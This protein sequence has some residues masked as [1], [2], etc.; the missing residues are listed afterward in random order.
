MCIIGRVGAGSVECRCVGPCPVCQEENCRKCEKRHN[1]LRKGWKRPWLLRTEPSGCDP[2][3]W[4]GT[5]WS[6]A[7][8]W[9]R[10]WPCL[11]SGAN[12][13][14]TCT[15][16]RA[17][18]RWWRRPP[19][20]RRWPRRAPDRPVHTSIPG[21][22]L[23][24]WTKWLVGNLIKSIWLKCFKTFK[25]INPPAGLLSIL[26]AT[27]AAVVA[28]AGRARVALAAWLVRIRIERIRETGPAA[29][30]VRTGC[31]EAKSVRAAVVQVG[32]TALV[33]IYQSDEMC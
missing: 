7:V 5:A 12:D 33:Q 31:V 2:A 9:T 11:G 3:S 8:P 27:L 20:K 26:D 18:R 32:W 10:C 1:L 17:S 25:W 24:N 13:G 23:G 28:V 22:C 30:H 15:G 4:S 14:S 29:A 6:W 16:R 19:V 21:S